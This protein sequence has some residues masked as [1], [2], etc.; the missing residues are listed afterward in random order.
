V[1]FAAVLE[2]DFTIGFDIIQNTKWRA[3]VYKTKV[4]SGVRQARE[5]RILNN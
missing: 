4:K 5:C 3:I 1:T 2:T